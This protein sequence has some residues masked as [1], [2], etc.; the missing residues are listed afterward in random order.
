MDILNINDLSGALK[1]V[2]LPGERMV[3]HREAGRG[4][5]AGVGYLED[6][7]MVVVE[8]GRPHLN[9]DVEFIV[10]RAL[11]T[12]AGRM[13]F[14]RLGGDGLRVAVR[15]AGGGGGHGGGG[16]SPGRP[17]EARPAAPHGPPS[18]TRNRRRLLRDRCLSA[19]SAST[20][21]QMPDKCAAARDPL[22][23]CLIHAQG[24]RRYCTSSGIRSR[25]RFALAG[26]GGVADRAPLPSGIAI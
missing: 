22:W 15:N 4:S 14:G 8:H 2:V 21:A 11:Q 10:T 24:H 9:E 26:Q 7:T 17:A 12:S 18:R 13:I 20:R 5:R 25:T 6:G 19:T 16:P 3:V 1:P 23:I